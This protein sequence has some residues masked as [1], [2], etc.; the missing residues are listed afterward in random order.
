MSNEQHKGEIH[1][2]SIS[3]PETMYERQDLSAGA[4]IGF[5][6]GLVVVVGLLQIIVWGL[7]GF[8]SGGKFAHQPASAGI[9]TRTGSLPQAQ[10]PV[11]RFPKPALQPNDA[12]D[13][14]K[15]LAAEHE[16]LN[17]Y[18]YVDQAQGVVHIPIERAI[19]ILAKQGLPTRQPPQLPPEATFGSG[20]PTVAGAGGGVEPARKASSVVPQH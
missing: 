15:F 4:I 6:V 14:A 20:L 19:D 16:E 18:G 10:D 2:E 17:S 7:Y 11:N 1:N 13:M 5:L 12:A 8:F 9:V 3:N